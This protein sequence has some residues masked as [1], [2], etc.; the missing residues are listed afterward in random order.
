[1]QKGVAKPVE[2]SKELAELKQK[3]AAKER[4]YGMFH[5]IALLLV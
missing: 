2:A 1:L 3:L 4:D 5:A